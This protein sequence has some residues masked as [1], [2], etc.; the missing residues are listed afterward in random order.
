MTLARHSC[1]QLRQRHHGFTRD[2]ALTSVA[3]TPS[4][5]GRELSDELGVKLRK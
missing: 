5:R 1:P 4:L 3:S 2:P